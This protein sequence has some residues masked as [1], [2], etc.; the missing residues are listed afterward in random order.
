MGAEVQQTDT[1][2]M[3]DFYRGGRALG[4]GEQPGMFDENGLRTAY[5][6]IYEWVDGI[7]TEKPYIKYKTMAHVMA[8]LRVLEFE[9]AAQLILSRFPSAVLKGKTK[10]EMY[11][12]FLRCA[13]RMPELVLAREERQK[14]LERIVETGL[15]RGEWFG[16][17]KRKCQNVVSISECKN[18]RAKTMQQKYSTHQST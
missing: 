13:P 11:T 10:K 6:K 17:P 16:I 5:N 14:C 2:I 18:R 7:E 3:L 8:Y 15:F 12:L 4:F 1:D 9:V